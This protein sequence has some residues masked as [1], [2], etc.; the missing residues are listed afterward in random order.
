MLTKFLQ[1]IPGFFMNIHLSKDGKISFPYLDDKFLARQNGHYMSQQQC[2]EFMLSVIEVADLS[3][4]SLEMQLC[5]QEQSKLVTTLGIKF[6]GKEKLYFELFGGYEQLSDQSSIWY[7][8]ANEMTDLI[9]W[10]QHLICKDESSKDS[11]DQLPD[12]ILTVNKAGIIKSCSQAVQHLFGYKKEQ[13]F[14]HLVSMLSACQEKLTADHLSRLSRSMSTLGEEI[15]CKTKAGHRFPTE[16]RVV[17]LSGSEDTD[18]LIIL[19]DLSEQ[20]ASEAMLQ[21]FYYYDVLTMMPGRVE[22]EKLLE[23]AIQLGKSEQLYSALILLDIEDFRQFNQQY[24]SDKGDRLLV[25]F[26]QRLKQ[27]TR[28]Q[29]SVCRFGGDEFVLLINGL[30]QNLRQS[31]QQLEEL[32]QRIRQLL[33]TRFCLQ[34]QLYQLH[35]QSK[36]IVFNCNDSSAPQLL[37]QLDLAAYQAR[38]FDTLQKKEKPPVD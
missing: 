3:R 17:P 8:Y 13:L 36:S 12:A 35:F 38:L 30:N 37:R 2:S 27:A 16:L 1:Q 15:F 33:T 4:L 28:A 5:I 23:E 18:L 9:S 19:R 29:D 34:Q 6:P 10:H 21:Q 7:V 26:A 31:E 14:D 32:L 25:L 20:K 24:G 22:L 11:L